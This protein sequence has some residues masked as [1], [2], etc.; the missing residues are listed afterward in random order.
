MS[1]WVMH[2]QSFAAPLRKKLVSGFA[3]IFCSRSS[4]RGCKSWTFPGINVLKVDLRLFFSCE[5]GDLLKSLV[6]FR[7]IHRGVSTQC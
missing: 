7:P 6:R 1:Y 3:E 2:K 4:W 5:V